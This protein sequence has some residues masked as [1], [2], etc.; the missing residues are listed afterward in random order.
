MRGKPTL[1]ITSLRTYILPVRHDLSSPREY[2]GCCEDG[3]P[4]PTYSHPFPHFAPTAGTGP[5]TG[6]MGRGVTVP[7]PPSALAPPPPP[8]ARSP[9]YQ[10]RTG[11]ALG[12]LSHHPCGAADSS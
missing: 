4:V 11:D 12:L 5:V 8:T 6:G 2:P 10:R 3:S 9:C 7:R 1:L